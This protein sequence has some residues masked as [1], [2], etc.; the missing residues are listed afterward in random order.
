M[1]KLS[2]PGFHL[3]LAFRVSEGES[4]AKSEFSFSTG[5]SLGISARVETWNRFNGFRWIRVVLDKPLRRLT[6]F[7]SRP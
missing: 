6:I 4:L 3:Y 2:S 5:F 7:P 1:R